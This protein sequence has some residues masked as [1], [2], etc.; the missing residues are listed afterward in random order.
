M[1]KYGY[2]RV[3]SEGLDTSSQVEA[4]VKSGV[5]RS[6]IYSDCCSGSVPLPEREGFSRLAEELNDGDEVLA[7]S[8]DRI[9]RS[10]SDAESCVADLK[11]KGVSLRALSK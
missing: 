6:D 7:R 8:L 9:S 3:S 10:K 1:A 2:A 4:L 5:D 11:A